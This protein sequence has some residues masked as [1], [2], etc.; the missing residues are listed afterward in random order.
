ME[1]TYRL[2]FNEKQQAFHLD[3]YSHQENTFGWITVFDH[4]TDVEFK[5]FECYL[6]SFKFSGY[7]NEII[8][9]AAKGAT[10]FINEM[11]D[12]NLLVIKTGAEKVA[13]HDIN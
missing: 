13:F 3:N 10:N 6:R 12:R 5:I 4:C 2:E 1:R 8:I 9:T 11:T 7:T